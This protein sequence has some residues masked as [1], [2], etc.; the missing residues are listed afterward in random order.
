[1]LEDAVRNPQAAH[2]GILRRRHIK[3]PVIAPAEIIRGIRRCVV[4]RLLLQPRIGIERMLFALVLLLIGEFLARCRDLVLRLDMHSLRSGRLRICLA[5]IAATETTA[6]PADLQAGG[7]TFE[8]AFLL[9]G[10]VDC[11]RFNF[12][13][14]DEAPAATLGGVN[15]NGMTAW[16]S[17][18]PQT[19]RSIPGTVR[20]AS[21]LRKSIL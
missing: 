12:H 21:L 8:V 14:G 2:V 17:A 7:E 4:E 13:D 19:R 1:M 5:G 20:P 15:G 3:Q 18:P 6:D 9:G 16:R 10:K 11:E